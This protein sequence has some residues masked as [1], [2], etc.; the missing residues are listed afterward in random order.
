MGVSKSGGDGVL[1][2]VCRVVPPE[3]HRNEGRCK[4]FQGE[5][6]CLPP[7]CFF[8]NAEMR[9]EIMELRR[10]LEGVRNEM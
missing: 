4:P 5:G 3:M 1:R 7:V 8:C 6:V 9:K 10:E 2:D